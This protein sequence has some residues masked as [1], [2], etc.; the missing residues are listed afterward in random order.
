[1][2]RPRL[3]E[4]MLQLFSERNL[5]N[6][7][8]CLEHP[9]YLS[10][11]TQ[12]ELS[13]PPQE[14]VLAFTH[15]SF[16]HEY[17]VPHQEL[18]E[19]FGDAVVQLIVTSELMRLY[20]KETEGKLSKLRSSIVNENTLAKVG[21]YLKLQ[22]LILVGRGEY[23]KELHLQDAVISD[24]LEAIVAKIYI[25]HGIEF[26]TARFLSWL[27]LSVPDAFKMDNLETFDAKSK[28][29][30]ASLAKYKTLPRYSAD[31]LTEGFLV[32]LWVNESVIAEGVYTS[33]KIGERELARQALENKEF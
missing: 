21:T 27:E 14:F 31:T 32:K 7:K 17:E 28:L 20:P 26:A 10:F 1:M 8:V 3:H 24:T 4:Q 33:K 9:D 6:L 18:S 19:F 23:K 16:A 22:D 15:T 13:V 2:S 11:L 5:P 12:H 30:E 29:Q 25:H